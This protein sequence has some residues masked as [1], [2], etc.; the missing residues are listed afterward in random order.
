MAQPLLQV[1]DELLLT[2]NLTLLLAQ[3]NLQHFVA[4]E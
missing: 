4:L 2:E 3:I 1:L